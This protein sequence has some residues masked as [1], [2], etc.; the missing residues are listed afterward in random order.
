MRLANKFRGVQIIAQKTK[1]IIP[2]TVAVGQ[3]VDSPD[4]TTREIK[5]MKMEQNEYLKMYFNKSYKLLSVDEKLNSKVGDI[6]LIRKLN[7]PASQQRMFNIEKVLFKI[8]NIIDPITGRSADYESK[9]LEKHIESL[10]KS[11]NE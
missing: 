1:D 5:V 6:V 3:V 10:T 9:I 8:D 4:K 7:N 11:S 2:Y